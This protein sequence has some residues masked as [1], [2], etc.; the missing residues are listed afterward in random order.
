MYCICSIINK[1]KPSRIQIYNAKAQNK[2]A[3]KIQNHAFDYVGFGSAETQ[4]VFKFCP[5]QNCSIR[6]NRLKKHK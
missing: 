6:L 4:V 3:Y 5:L 1:T 2:S